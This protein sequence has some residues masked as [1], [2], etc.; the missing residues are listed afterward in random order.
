M[1]AG[2]AVPFHSFEEKNQVDELCLWQKPTR[3]EVVQTP[4]YIDQAINDRF[5]VSATIQGIDAMT[6]LDLAQC[7]ERHIFVMK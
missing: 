1:L 6:G 3:L 2:E 7:S 5:C 4:C